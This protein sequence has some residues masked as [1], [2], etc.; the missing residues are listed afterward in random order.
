MGEKNPMDQASLALD[1]LNRS[2]MDTKARGVVFVEECHAAVWRHIRTVSREIDGLHL[3]MAQVRFITGVCECLIEYH[4][5]RREEWHGEVDC[6]Y[7][8]RGR[9]KAGG[10]SK[11]GIWMHADL[12]LFMNHIYEIQ[13]KVR[14]TRKEKQS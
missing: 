4:P 14:K 5:M 10:W 11:Q 9:T 12:I 8:R 13:V 3:F 7:V 6:I 1:L 2:K